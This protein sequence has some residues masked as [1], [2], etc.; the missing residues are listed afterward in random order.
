MQNQ[1]DPLITFRST[2]Q[3]KNSKGGDRLTL[4]I[5]QDQVAVLINVLNQNSGNERGVKLDIHTAKKT[6][7]EGRSFLST[8]AFVKAVQEAGASTGA[9]GGRYV[10]KTYDE[11]KVAKT[12]REL[13]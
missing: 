5:N 9:I 3:G 1:K 7:D 6:T 13:A 12:K 11:E 10:K 2:Q 4:Y 8:F